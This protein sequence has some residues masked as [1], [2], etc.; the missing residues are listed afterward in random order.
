MMNI[1][2]KEEK[3]LQQIL[4]LSLGMTKH[5]LNTKKQYAQLQSLL[6][7]YSSDEELISIIYKV[8]KFLHRIFLK[9]QNKNLEDSYQ[10][11]VQESEYLK[12]EQA[13]QKYEAQARVHAKSSQ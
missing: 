13:L 11:Y 6:T 7:D 5:I 1:E 9:T 3:Q 12:L 2:E 4:Q 8:L 10:G